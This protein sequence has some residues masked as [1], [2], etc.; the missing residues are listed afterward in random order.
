MPSLNKY[1]KT[2]D[3]KKGLKLSDFTLT[4]MTAKQEQISNH[5]HRYLIMMT[6]FGIGDPEDLLNELKK[7]VKRKKIIYNSSGV[8]YE[9]KFGIP[10]IFNTSNSIVKIYSTGKSKKSK[11]AIS[12]II[13]KNKQNK[14][15]TNHKTK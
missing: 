5:R 11:K 8:S 7:H 15:L 9:A 10:G 1:L 3:I 4:G 14:Q 2:F 13:T 6:F 12:P